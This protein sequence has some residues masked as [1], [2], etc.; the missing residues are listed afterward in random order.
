MSAAST[1]G[2]AGTAGQAIPGNPA[3]AR[4]GT[5]VRFEHQSQ[6]SAPSVSSNSSIKTTPVDV[7]QLLRCPHCQKDAGLKRLPTGI[8]TCELC[9]A[10][11]PML[12]EVPDLAPHLPIADQRF[13]WKQQVMNTPTFARLYETVGWRPFH[14][15]VANHT[16]LE[17]EIVNVLSLVG[18]QPMTLAVDLA[19]GT[20]I[21]AREMA[22][23]HPE[24]QVLGLDISPGMLQHAQTL[25][26]K[27]QLHQ[28]HF[29][30]ADVYRLPLPD[31]SVDHINCC[32]ALHLFPSLSPIWT[33]I[34]RVLKP[35]G[36]FTGM[37]LMR[38]PLGPYSFQ[39]FLQTRLSFKF[40]EPE[41]F[42]EELAAH[43]LG[44]FFMLN[45]HSA[46]LFRT[47][48]RA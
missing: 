29:A 44:D 35:G 1:A 21:Y 7:L 34:A 15:Y 47:V 20:G 28:L 12:K 40:F 18:R 36:I 22:R 37:T 2:T 46:L 30:R 16:S 27:A 9:G 24:A 42:K 23:R 11:L 39:A 19:C 48:R 31:A 3:S 26:E 4:V 25:A 32:A 45:R 10:S 13:G 38:R 17:Q 8:A 14:A 6:M 41:L 5:S 33:E 43:G